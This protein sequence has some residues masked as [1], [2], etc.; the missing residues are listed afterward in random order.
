LNAPSDHRVGPGMILYLMAA[1]RLD[2]A[3]IQ[4]GNMDGQ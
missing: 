1:Q 2:P 3:Q 4:W